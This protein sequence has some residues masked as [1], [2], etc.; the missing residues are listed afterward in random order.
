MRLPLR[1]LVMAALAAVSVVW[2]LGQGFPRS[3]VPC[4]LIRAPRKPESAA[5]TARRASEARPS[6]DGSAQ[7]PAADAG[8]R[9]PA[10]RPRDRLVW[11]AQGVIGMLIRLA[12]VIA[13]LCAPLVGCHLR[14]R[15]RR[16]VSRY[17]IACPR[18]EGGCSSGWRTS[19]KA[20]HRILQ[21]E[22]GLTRLL[23]GQPHLALEWH[24]LPDP[25]AP[26]VF[27][28]A[29]RAAAGFARC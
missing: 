11:I 7:R 20:S 6:G 14:A 15:R 23:F 5:P 24:S 13:G 2:I 17:P 25:H 21:R 10:G 19:S 12:I 3:G 18:A 22:R 1:L 29:P 16:R 26:G 27:M 9:T 4:D 28:R 8:Q